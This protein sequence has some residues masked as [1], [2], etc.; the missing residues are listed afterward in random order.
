MLEI[1]K[2]FSRS[3]STSERTHEQL[4]WIAMRI[5]KTSGKHCSRSKVIAILVQREIDRLVRDGEID[6]IDVEAEGDK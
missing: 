3:D 4:D 5:T 2:C 6:P 1:D